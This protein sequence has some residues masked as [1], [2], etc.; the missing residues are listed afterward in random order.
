MPLFPEQCKLPGM[1]AVRARANPSFHDSLETARPD[2]R[3]SLRQWNPLFK[4]F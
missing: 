2:Y 4:K 1:T 3:P